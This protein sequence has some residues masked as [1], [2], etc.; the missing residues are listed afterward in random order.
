M[1]S[2][3]GSRAEFT[4]ER[5]VWNLSSCCR[6]KCGLVYVSAL[7]YFWN[8]FPI[9]FTKS[10]RKKESEP[11]LRGKFSNRSREDIDE[12]SR[13]E[14]TTPLPEVTGRLLQN[15]RLRFPPAVWN[16]TVRLTRQKCLRFY[17]PVERRLQI[18]TAP[19]LP[20]A[21][22][23]STQTRSSYSWRNAP[24]PPFEKSPF[25]V[26]SGESG[27]RRRR[28]LGGFHRSGLFHA[29]IRAIAASCMS[30]FSSFKKTF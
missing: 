23:C 30:F 13:A 18:S 22:R 19:E 24:P 17:W 3:R 12:N 4:C 26:T 10:E 28:V 16:H 15:T 27:R 1:H 8:V 21:V 9:F 11:S 5:A 6:E 7:W 14:V 20:H 25:G 29:V 2:R